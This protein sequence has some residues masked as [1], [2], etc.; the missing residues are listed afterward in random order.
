M[1]F[2]FKCYSTTSYKN[3]NKIDNVDGFRLN[4]GLYSKLLPRILLVYPLI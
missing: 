3:D 4:I 1:D 2:F